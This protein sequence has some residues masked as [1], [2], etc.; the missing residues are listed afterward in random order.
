MCIFR[1]LPRLLAWGGAVCVMKEARVRL[2]RRGAW[3]WPSDK[4]PLWVSAL[5][6]V[7]KVILLPLSL[8][9]SQLPKAS[10]HLS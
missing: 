1:I 9:L 10:E 8:L 5:W 7:F 6:E 2:I 4:G 3:R